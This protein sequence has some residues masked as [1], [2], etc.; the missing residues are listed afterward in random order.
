MLISAGKNKN[1]ENEVHESFYDF[2]FTKSTLRANDRVEA[3]TFR[4]TSRDKLSLI[5]LSVWEPRAKRWRPL[6]LEELEKVERK[7]LKRKEERPKPMS[8]GEVSQH[9]FRLPQVESV[10]PVGTRRVRFKYIFY[11]EV[12]S[13][14][15]RKALDLGVSLKLAAN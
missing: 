9:E 1:G 12:G 11:R 5:D 8:P 13:R 7:S 10:M 15:K 6:K 4:V 2:S 3:L 14:R